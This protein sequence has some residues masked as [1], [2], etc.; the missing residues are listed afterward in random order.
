MRAVSTRVIQGL[1]DYPSFHIN[2][3]D[4]PSGAP[5]Q[6]WIILIAD[7]Y[8]WNANVLDFP[9]WDRVNKFSRAEIIDIES[10]AKV[11]GYKVPVV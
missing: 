1:R 9:D 5:D 10:V 8:D 4:H 7:K 11:G 2:N 6:N 3:F